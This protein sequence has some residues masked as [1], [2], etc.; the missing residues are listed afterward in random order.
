M[1]LKSYMLVR[2]AM[3]VGEDVW[4]GEKLGMLQQED[5]SRVGEVHDPDINGKRG[6]FW[7]RHLERKRRRK[8]TARRES[9]LAEREARIQRTEFSIKKLAREVTELAGEGNCCYCVYDRY[10]RTALMGKREP[11]QETGADTAESGLEDVSNR[12]NAE[13]DRRLLLTVL[14]RR[15]FD[16]KEFTD[17]GGRFWVEQLM[18]EAVLP[19]FVILGTAACIPELIEKYAHG[20]KSLRWILPQA[21]YTGELDEFVED[22]YTEFGLAISMQVI[23]GFR[24]FKGL[25][26]VCPLPSN[27]LD[28]SGEPGIGI[29]GVAEGSIWLDMR[30]VEEKRRRIEV[31][32][33]S[34][35]YF[36]MKEKWQYAQ[37]RCKSPRINA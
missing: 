13:N 36:S 31:R 19:H 26:L 30:S 15:Y 4:F 35:F 25:Q 16:W 17:Y 10:V 5:C 22:F 28:F 20:M 6:W 14:W 12:S 18:P 29:S 32:G 24:D 3:D 27:I 8:E 1:G 33:L 11:D 9:L 37:R 7:K 23:P 21:D 2:V 34:I